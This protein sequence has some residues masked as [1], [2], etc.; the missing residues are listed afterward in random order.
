MKVI[1]ISVSVVWPAEISL[2]VISH[3]C[4]REQGG[5]WTW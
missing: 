3:A 4:T 2:D 5:K 1:I